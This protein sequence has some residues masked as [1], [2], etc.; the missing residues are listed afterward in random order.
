ML[1]NAWRRFLARLK[2]GTRP[3]T[4]TVSRR[5]TG[6]L[7]LERLEDR[8]TPATVSWINPQGGSWNDPSN[9]STAALPTAGDVV[10]ID[11]PSN[12]TVQLSDGAASVNSLQ[13]SDTLVLDGGSLSVAGDLVNTGAIHL[14]SDGG[15]VLVVN[16]TLTNAPGSLLSA[17]QGAGGVQQIDAN[18]NNQGTVNVDPGVGLVI[19]GAA[20][21]GPDFTQAG[22]TLTVPGGGWVVQVGGVFHYT[23][24][25]LPAEFVAFNSELDVEA[26]VTATAVIEIRGTQNTLDRN[27]APGVTLWVQGWNGN[28]DAMLTA[29]DGAVND[30]TI[31]L[32]SGGSAYNSDLAV[33]DGGT[34]T[35]ASDGVIDVQAGSGGGRDVYGNWINEGTVDVE[36]GTGL[37]LQGAGSAGPDFTQAGGS[38]TVPGGS[39]VVQYG[40]VFH[41]TGGALPAEFVAFNSE[42]DV[43]ATV[44]A[45]AVIEIRGTE[46]VLDQ[47]LAPGVTLWVQGCDWNGNATLTAAPGAVN[48]GTI[49]LE[50]LHHDFWSSNF[51]VGPSFTNAA[52]GVIDVQAGSGGGTNV[53]GSWVNEG[54]INVEAGAELFLL[55]DAA[56]GPNITQ[57]GGTLNAGSG[58]L[59][60][61]GGLFDYTGGAIGG[62]FVAAGAELDVE[63]PTGTGEIQVRGQDNRL[64]QNLAPGVMLWVQGCD[65]NGDATLTAADGAVNDGVIDLESIGSWGWNSDLCVAPG[66]VFTNAATG[67]IDVQ[68]GAG[69]GRLL[70][71]ILINQGVLEADAGLQ[72]SGDVANSGTITVAAG[73]EVDIA[74]LNGT[75]STLS[76]TAGSLVVDGS[77]LVPDGTLD[78][79]GGALDGG[80]TLQVQDAQLSFG[81]TATGP[82]PVQ[83]VGQGDVLLTN[84]GGV[85]LWVRGDDR[86][87]PGVLSVAPDAVN[88]GTILLDSASTYWG[89]SLS[90]QDGLD[91]TTTGVIHVTGGSG[92]GRSITGDLSNEGTLIV[93][94]GAALDIDGG[95]DAGPTLTQNDGVIEA[96]GAVLLSGGFLDF[97][98][99]AITGSFTVDGSQIYVDPNVTD[100]SQVRVVGGGDVLLDNGSASTTLLVQGDDAYDEG[101]LTVAPDAT[102]AGT[103]QLDSASG[104]WGSSLVLQDML[105]NLPGGSILVTPGSGGGRSIV[106][107]IDNEGLLQV[108]SG[109]SVTITGATGAG[110]TFI[111][112]GGLIQA[113]GQLVLDGGL[114]DFESGDVAG[115]FLVNDAQIYVGPGATDPATVYVVGSGDTLLGNEGP[116]VTLQ[117]QGDDGFGQGVLT[118]SA[119]AV[120]AGAIVLDST[121]SYFGSALAAPDTLLNATGG[122]ITVADDGGGSRS[123]MGDFIN[124]GTI[125]VPSG[126]QLTLDGAA[127][128]SPTLIQ[129]GGLIAAAGRFVQDG[130]LFDFESGATVGDFVVNGASIYVGPNVAAPSLVEVAGS[131]NV[132]LGNDSPSTTLWLG[133]TDDYD[134]G[135]LTVA[136]GADNLGT[137]LLAS[138]SDYWGETLAAPDGMLNGPE[139][140]IAVYGGGGPADVTGTLTNDG[141][142]MLSGPVA[143]HIDNLVNDGIVGADSTGQS[144]A[145]GMDALALA[146]AAGWVTGSDNPAPAP[147]AA[148]WVAQVSVGSWLNQGV[149]AVDPGA[150]LDVTADG[151]GGDTFTQANG[152]VAAVGNFVVQGGLFHY[153]GGGLWGAVVVRDGQIRV[154]AT[155]TDAATVYVVGHLNVLLDNAGPVTLRVQGGSPLGDGD[156]VL[157]A[158]DGSTNAGTVQLESLD[159]VHHGYFYV[160]D[161]TFI[162]EANGTIRVELP[163]GDSG[164]ASIMAGRL[165]DDGDLS[166]TTGL[167]V[168]AALQ[169]A[170][171][172]DPCSCTDDS[173]DGGSSDGGDGSGD[174]SGGDGSGDGSGGSVADAQANQARMAL[175]PGVGDGVIV[176]AELNTGPDASGLSY[177]CTCGYV[178]PG[179]S[180]GSSGDNDAVNGLIGT[181]YNFGNI[182]VNTYTGVSPLTNGAW[183]LFQEGV[184]I[185]WDAAQG[186]AGGASVIANQVF[187]T[188]T[189]NPQPTSSLMK[190]VEAAARRGSFCPT[191]ARPPT[192]S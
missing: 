88:A 75:P 7:L 84:Q 54:T 131:G 166:D 170:L 89:S 81:P 46:N 125:Y 134:A 126:Q 56:G 59:A 12:V 175:T 123:L 92:G 110:P 155:V 23:G 95:T 66:G 165:E 111:Q 36:T 171:Q 73:V 181:I 98:G 90:L 2:R 55:P 96:D 172:W 70:Q 102:N 11:L 25:S 142:L 72:W 63:D 24:G 145:P 149:V 106:G 47:N 26:T 69:G 162:N 141:Y 32:E 164:A 182:I 51:L 65:W 129:S 189:Y 13:L 107:D 41:Y 101:V 78:V 177:S 58:A 50:T 39:W 8:V 154:E 157:N 35:N 64:D 150:E 183:N 144:V 93:D 30:G 17:D 100:P 163:P 74:D 80:G 37:N 16:G 87:G 9:W 148:G 174:G 160:P 91:N 86:F 179:S 71:G 85:T 156:A 109:E 192:T 48:A 40:G 119:G 151:S 22:G 186:L 138:S 120:N 99:G 79:E 21:S 4:P 34:F 118:A 180:G 132:L 158:A 94:A 18:I 114:F 128:A 103:I 184:S 117:V 190:G 76:Q 115:S 173:G 146:D 42:L 38:L 31:L 124:A 33:A 113:D 67:V 57:A 45:T 122:L 135:V 61:I 6:R 136:P 169:P 77:L 15:A 137:L 62:T 191:S 20:S 143:L 112:D 60:Q 161:G 44:T 168:T 29:A 187:G 105:D 139:G 147:A 104:Y 185:P 3:R 133:G 53:C 121:S 167:P 49:L 5:Q 127:G 83:V 116:S 159:G 1:V 82:L 52:T 27:L 140:R 28:G 152:L 43:E 178:G 14:A 68:A 108:A 10:V 188:P 19:Q 176:V 153:T 130:G 97:E